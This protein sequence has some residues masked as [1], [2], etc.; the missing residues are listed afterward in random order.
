[1]KYITNQN[2]DNPQKVFIK[3]MHGIFW[4]SALF[5]SFL[6]FFSPILT[7]SMERYSM[8]GETAVKGYE[9]VAYA[10]I[11][12]VLVITAPILN[13]MLHNA[14]LPAKKKALMYF[15]LATGYVIAFGTCLI[16]TAVR[17]LNTENHIVM[18]SGGAYMVFILNLLHLS[19][20]ALPTM[21]MMGEE[22]HEE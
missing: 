22:D 17:I 13:A 20:G 15:A 21:W 9:M 19:L 18:F 6:T 1:M 2:D 5:I 8:A 12:S 14:E 16:L 11:L 7:E 10:P 4:T 3:R